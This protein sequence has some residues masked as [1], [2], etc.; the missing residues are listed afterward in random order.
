MFAG[1]GV[2]AQTKAAPYHS[3]GPLCKVQGT[4]GILTPL[5]RNLS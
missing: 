4:G 3:R 5:L 1:L 2:D